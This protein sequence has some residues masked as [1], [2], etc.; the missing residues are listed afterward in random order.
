MSGR[1][2]LKAI[3]SAI[4]TLIFLVLIATLFLVVTTKLSGGEPQVFGYQLKT[5]L[6]GSMEPEIKTGSVLSIKEADDPT[7]FQKGDVIT[8]HAEDE[9][10]IT[11]RIMEVK[12]DGES[13]ITKGDANNAPDKEPVM[14]ENIIGFYTGLT[15]PY[16]GYI[17]YF[18]NTSEGAA[19]LLIIP[20]ICL[21]LY[22]AVTIWRIFRELDADK[23]SVK[24]N[25]D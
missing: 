12:Q 3:S 23:K 14:A 8:F 4:T 13:Y 22:T 24:S 5:V 20:G 25:E 19:L 18:S 21:L 11:H 16:L 9:L 2:M 17:L 6:S 7:S 15:I 1:R 10:L